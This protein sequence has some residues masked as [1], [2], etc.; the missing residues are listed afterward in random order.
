MPRTRLTHSLE[1]AQIG[2]RRAEDLGADPDVVDT[3]G[4]DLLDHVLQVLLQVVNAA[5]GGGLPV[6]KDQHDLALLPPIDEPQV[7]TLRVRKQV[8]GFAEVV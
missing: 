7:I 8:V 6:R 1:V 3:A 2:R 5:R 4:L